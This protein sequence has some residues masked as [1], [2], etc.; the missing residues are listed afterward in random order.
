MP[1]LVKDVASNEA[2][3]LALIENLQREDLNPIEEAQA[4]QRLLESE[5]YT[6]D[7]LA[8]RLGKNR[9][10]IAN[11]LRLLRLDQSHQSMVVEGR[12]TAGHAR[13]LL[14][15]EDDSQ[16]ETLATKIL[17]E[18]LSV[19]EAEEWVRKERETPKAA[20]NPTPTEPRVTPLQPYYESVA[21]DL[22]RALGA[23][24]QIQSRG[25]KGRISISFESLDELRRLKALLAP[26]SDLAKTA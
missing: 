11:A 18:D 7:V 16:R 10:T 22:G 24:V 25:R 20:A 4:Y 14:A 15:V 12:L 2:L 6:Q 13:C 23:D 8:R 9:S 21:A 26:G 17:A 1:V 5:D 3:E 19:R